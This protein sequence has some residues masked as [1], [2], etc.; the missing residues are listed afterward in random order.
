MR[1]EKN[2]SREKDKKSINTESETPCTKVGLTSA[3]NTFRASLGILLCS[4]VFLRPWDDIYV[5][6]FPTEDGVENKKKKKR[7]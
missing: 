7:T 1:F 2:L 5:E 3:N 6:F 4:P